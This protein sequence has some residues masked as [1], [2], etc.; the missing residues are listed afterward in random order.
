MNESIGS[1]PS[2]VPIVSCTVA[3]RVPNIKRNISQ[4]R[5]KPCS[6]FL[7]TEMGQAVP[8]RFLG[9]VAPTTTYLYAAT[10]VVESLIL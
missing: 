2:L 9:I 10:E 4:Y 6:Y 3:A 1:L 5:T 7:T 8:S